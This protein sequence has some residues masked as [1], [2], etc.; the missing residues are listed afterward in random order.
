[1]RAL[2]SAISEQVQTLVHGE[3][4]QREQLEAL[5]TYA[6][7]DASTLGTATSPAEN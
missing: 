6:A 3:T 4:S 2:I 5:P 7:E 1:M